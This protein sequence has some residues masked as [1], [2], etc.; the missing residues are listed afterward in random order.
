MKKFHMIIDLEKCVGCFNCMLACKDEH[1]GNEWL[2]YTEEQQK[3]DQKWINPEMHERGVAPFTEI[4]YV[5]KM[6]Q[7]CD[8]PPCANKFPDI[9]R[10]RDDGI[11]LIDPQRARGKKELV[12]ACPFGMISWN[13]EL[14][15]AQKCTMCVHLMTQGWKEPRCVQ[16][17]PLRA[18]SVMFCEDHEFEEVV[19]AQNLKQLQEGSHRPRVM[20]KNLYK[21]NKC[22]VTGGMSY[23]ENNIEMAAT[24][25][26]ARLILNGEVITEVEADF[27]GEFKIDKIPK[28]SGK[29]QIELIL[30]GY[31]NVTKS[32]E[33]KEES[34]NI[35]C[36]QFKKKVK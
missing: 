18:L 8:N 19:K 30:D 14:E 34:I 5:T 21:Y 13:E 23:I 28:N 35:G 32:F 16:S 17:C 11:V 29:F 3:H 31:E 36:V 26:V 15:T 1:V 33:I 27:L 6:C 9:I 7:H 2:P 25:G 20:Y 12:K 22:F 24:E 4:C 10:K